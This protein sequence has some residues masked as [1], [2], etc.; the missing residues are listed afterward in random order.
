MCL[1][2]LLQKPRHCLLSHLQAGSPSTSD[3]RCVEIEVIRV[4]REREVSDARRTTHCSLTGYAGDVREK[5]TVNPKELGHGH[6]GGL[7][8]LHLD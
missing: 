4:T 7:S 6:Y 5:Y 1:F 2:L 3:G 8:G